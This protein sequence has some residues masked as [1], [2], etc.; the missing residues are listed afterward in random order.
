MDIHRIIRAA[1]MECDRTA[2][3]LAQ[4]ECRLRLR[5]TL[6]KIP[7]VYRQVLFHHLVDRP[8]VKYIARRERVAVGTVL[9]RIFTAKRLLRAAWEG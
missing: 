8:P 4:S 3:T 7:A 9:S 6:R 5:E 1:L 2:D